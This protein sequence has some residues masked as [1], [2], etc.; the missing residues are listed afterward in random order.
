ML[1]VNSQKAKSTPSKEVPDIMPMTFNDVY[2]FTRDFLI[3]CNSFSHLS[4]DLFYKS[5]YIK[6]L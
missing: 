5:Q 6:T 1:R 3:L 4:L 2:A